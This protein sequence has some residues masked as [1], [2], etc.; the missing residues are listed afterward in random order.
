MLIGQKRQ[1]KIYQSCEFLQIVAFFSTINGIMKT[2]IL[3]GGKGTRLKE[4]TEF[5]PKPMIEVGGKPL[6]WHIMQIYMHYGYSDF[7]IALGYKGE[8]I[9][10][11]FLNYYTT[12]NNFTLDSSSGKITILDGQKHKTFTVTLVDTGLETTTGGR[13]KRIAPFITG[14]EFMVTYGDGVADIDINKLVDFHHQKGSLGTISGVR[15]RSRF[16][17]IKAH[18]KNGLVLEFA[19]KPMMEEFLSGGFMV[20]KKEALKYFT[21]N[22]MEEALVE[23]TKNKELS[24]YEHKGFWEAVDT[25][26]ELE[27]LNDLWGEGRPWAIW[28]K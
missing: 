8:I 15:K 20:F 2:V 14:D 23:M 10:D 12:F 1:I 19:Q 17:L 3:C 28:E 9:K 21:D 5:K 16:G 11:F 24:M 25:Y 6:L 4:E 27:M 22:I 18:D 13:I 7:I 26:N